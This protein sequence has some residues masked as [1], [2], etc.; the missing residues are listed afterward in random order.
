MHMETNRRMYKNV[1]FFDARQ[2][3][4]TSSCKQDIVEEMIASSHTNEK[5]DHS[6]SVPLPIVNF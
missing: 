5:I 2:L 1:T 3:S 4:E 6:A